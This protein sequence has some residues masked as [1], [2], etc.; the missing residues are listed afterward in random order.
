VIKIF[1]NFK[2]HKAFKTSYTIDGIIGGKLLGVKSKEFITFYSWEDFNIVR[3]IDV[4]NLKTVYWSESGE[5]IILAL[6]DTFYLLSYNES[7]VKQAFGSGMEVDEDGLEEAFTFMQ[8]FNEPI[9]SGSWI[10]SEC[11][12]FTT[13]KG[14]LNYLIGE[15]IINFG[16]V[17][18]K[19]FI[20]G[21]VATQNRLYLINRSHD[22]ISY[23]LLTSTIA[24]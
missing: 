18:K 9:A 16:V 13:T 23:N 3:R 20:M 17:D 8:E 14:K 2:E 24:F 7:Y 10:T 21:Y 1:N 4:A 11:F 22:I 5:R 19:M 6:E 12:A 15:K